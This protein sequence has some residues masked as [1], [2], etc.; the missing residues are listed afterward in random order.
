MIDIFTENL[1]PQISS[2]IQEQYESY[3][4][5]FRSYADS[6]NDKY[7]GEITNNYEISC[8]ILRLAI[9]YKSVIIPFREVNSCFKDFKRKEDIRKIQIGTYFFS[10]R[11]ERRIQNM[12]TE[13]QEILG[14]YNIPEHVLLFSD[15]KDF[16]RNL[17]VYLNN[18]H[19]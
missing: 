9:F 19:A 18:K 3:L 7:Y 2:Q 1:P 10:S 12:Y 14:K 17:N 6:N 5:I 13:L 15:I 11:E 16:A 8:F 4:S